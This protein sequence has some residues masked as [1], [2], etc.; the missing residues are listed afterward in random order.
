MR[1]FAH[2]AVLSAAVLAT[3]FAQPPVIRNKLS[4]YVASPSRVVDMMLDM[5]RVK[6]GDVVYDLGSGDG[7][8]LIAA[9]S[10]R[11]QAVGVE[12]NA[13]LVADAT[14]EIA[15]AGVSDRARVVQGDVL[16]SDI[17]GAPVVSIYM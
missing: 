5:A 6:P 2:V 4:P 11:A 3:A 1:R 10:R 17:S 16:N 7:R 8:I 9:A 14:A 12:I 15:R 13:K